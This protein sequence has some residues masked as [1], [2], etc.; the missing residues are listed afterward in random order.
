MRWNSPERRTSRSTAVIRYTPRF[1]PKTAWISSRITVEMLVRIDRPPLELK[2]RLRLSGVV[3]RISGGW[4]SIWRRSDWGV[5]PLRVRTRISG[6]SSPAS[7]KTLS[8]FIKRT[9]Q[10]TLDVIV[11]RPE[12]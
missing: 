6:K 5:S 3:M 2:S 8:Q 10:V 11:E 7:L 9:E 1:V 4:R 12:R